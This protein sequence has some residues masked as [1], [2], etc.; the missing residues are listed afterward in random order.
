LNY[1]LIVRLSGGIDQ[2]DAGKI[3]VK[4]GDMQELEKDDREG[5]R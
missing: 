4:L 5:A 2:D 1:C 3:I